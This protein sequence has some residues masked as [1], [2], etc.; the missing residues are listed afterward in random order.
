MR[1]VILATLG[2]ALGAAVGRGAEVRAHL[3]TEGLP[4]Y[5]RDRGRGV[6]SSMFGTYIQK[7]Q[8]IVYPY[9]EYYRDSN[10][11]YAPNELGFTQDR[12]Y[13]G[14]Y[15]ASEGLL[16]IGYGLSGRLVLE[17]EAAIIHAELETSSEDTSGLPPTIEESGLG[18]VESQ[19]RWRWT[20]ESPKRPEVFSYFETVFP[21]QE[22]GS[23]IG[24]TDWEF[25]LGSGAI[26]GFSWGTLTAR[27][28][29]EY[30]AAE[31]TFEIGEAAVEYLKRLSPAWRV[32]G[33]VEGTG[34]EI[35]LITEAQWHFAPYSYLK[36]NS[37]FGLTSKAPDWAPEIG[38]LFG[39]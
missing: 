13:R 37:A 28:A 25:Q 21:T 33:G 12:D 15:E 17:V 14:D 20:E 22:K 6:P 5:L 11:E 30:D 16:F 1:S 9:F 10:F 7:G 27:A 18:D 4:G 29:V 38:V 34:D 32:F 2:I 31:N 26:R 8:L 19:L 24:T 36:L 23:L 35:E 39:L 3:D